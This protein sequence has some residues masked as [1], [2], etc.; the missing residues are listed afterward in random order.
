METEP[1]LEHFRVKRKRTAAGKAA[2]AKNPRESW[3]MP[4]PEPLA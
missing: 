4:D 1:C 3:A 2:L